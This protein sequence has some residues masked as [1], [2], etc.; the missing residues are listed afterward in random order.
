M[1]QIIEEHYELSPRLKAYLQSWF[2]TATGRKRAQGLI[3][4]L[5]FEQFV[6][7]F[8]PRQIKTLEDA[9]AANRLRYLQQAANPFAFVLTWT[10]KE[11]RAAGVF[12]A[13]T[14]MVCSRQR[15]Q[16]IHHLRAGD[17]HRPDTLVKMRKPKS[18][19]HKANMKKPKSEEHKARMAEAARQRWARVR[20][21]KEAGK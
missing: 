9:I 15:S 14:A 16:Q 17:S 20:A 1:K 10:S 12:N 6:Q 5:T 13:S 21:E 18:A 8:K 19:S 2:N 3:V 7:L 11:A 4:E